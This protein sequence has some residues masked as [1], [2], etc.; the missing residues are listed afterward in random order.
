LIK[1]SSILERNYENRKEV[2]K[3][4]IYRYPKGG[5]DDEK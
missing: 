3:I 2:K 5:K 1:I 4:K